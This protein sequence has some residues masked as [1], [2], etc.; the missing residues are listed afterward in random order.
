VW[1]LRL[2]M[3]WASL[4]LLLRLLFSCSSLLAGIYVAI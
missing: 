3:V 2:E 4:R 1:G